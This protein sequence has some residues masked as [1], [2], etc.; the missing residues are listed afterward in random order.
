MFTDKAICIGIFIFDLACPDAV[1]HEP[2]FFVREIAGGIVGVC[3]F[4]RVGGGGA[5]Y[6]VSDAVGY[7]VLCIVGID[8]F[9]CVACRADDDDS[10]VAGGFSIR[11]HMSIT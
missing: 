8:M 4:G 2:M 11:T 6:F 3:R 7:C 5:V 9:Q 10:V 1:Y